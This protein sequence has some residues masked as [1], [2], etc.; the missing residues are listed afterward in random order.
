MAELKIEIPENYPMFK[1]TATRTFEEGIS[2]LGKE[3]PDLVLLFLSYPVARKDFDKISTVKS[4]C[5]NVPVIVLAYEHDEDIRP[6]IEQAL[7]F[8]ASDYIHALHGINPEHLCERATFFLSGT[9]L[10]KV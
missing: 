6:S 3:Q 8:G 4:V 2:I 7:R 10:N 5:P 9:G 1:V